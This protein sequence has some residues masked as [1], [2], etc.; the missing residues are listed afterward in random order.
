MELHYIECINRMRNV[1]FGVPKV[2]NMNCMHCVTI[3]VQNTNTYRECVLTIIHVLFFCNTFC[4][5]KYL[6]SYAPN[7]QKRRYKMYISY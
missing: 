7:V 6:V 2:V 4:S 3:W 1:I 5:N